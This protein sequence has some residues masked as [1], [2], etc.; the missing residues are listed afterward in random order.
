MKHEISLLNIVV[1]VP[2][3]LHA[4]YR[5]HELLNKHRCD[6]HSGACTCLPSWLELT[7]KKKN[8]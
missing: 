2:W 7:E 3:S 6:M 1:H 4:Q 5:T 8:V